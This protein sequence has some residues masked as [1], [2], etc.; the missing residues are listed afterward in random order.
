MQI[1]RGILA[2]SRNTVL[3]RFAAHHLATESDHLQCIESHLP[4]AHRSRL[5]RPGGW[6]AG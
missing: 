1:Y 3:R 5:L 4:A 2:I 6:R